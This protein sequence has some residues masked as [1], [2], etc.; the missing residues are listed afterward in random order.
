MKLVTI[1]S[2]PSQIAAFAIHKSPSPTGKVAQ[3]ILRSFTQKHSMEVTREHK[4]LFRNFK[5]SPNSET[6]LTIPNTKHPLFFTV[7][8]SAIGLGAD[9][10]HR[11]EKNKMKVLAY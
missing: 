5:T 6:E 8:A 3:T 7:D 10:F 11:N 2:N 1:Q 4:R 9:L